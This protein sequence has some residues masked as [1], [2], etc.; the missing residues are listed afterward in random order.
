MTSATQNSIAEQLAELCGRDH[1][2]LADGAL[3]VAPGDTLQIAAILRYANENG[4]VVTPYSGGTKQGWGNPVRPALYLDMARLAT[5]RE[6]TWQDL[7]CTVD[8]GCTW[9]ALQAGLVQHGQSVALDP[10]WPGRATVGGAIATNDSGSLRFYYGSLRDLV[11]GMTIVL[12]D[13]TIAKTGGKV[14]KNVAGYDLHKLM[15]GAFGTLGVITEVTFRLHAIPRHTESLTF[16]A[17]AASTLAPILQTIRGGHFSTQRLQLRGAR[18]GFFL[19]VELAALPSAL[20]TQSQSL[21]ALAQGAGLDIRAADPSAWLGRQQ[22]FLENSI[23]FK[24]S[25]LPTDVAYFADYL[26]A[27][28][29]TSVTQAQGIMTAAIDAEHAGLLPSLREEFAKRGGTLTLL[30]SHATLDPWGVAPDTLPL[31]H[32]VKRRFD[33]NSILNRG[34]FLGEI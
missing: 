28:G 21:T 13:G 19:D 9:S 31:M 23:N 2:R 4:L 22:M 14:V 30:Q 27:R 16:R 11:I 18:D 29:V 33:P 20:T 8:A 12:A 5:L 3:R 25:M 17:D 1:V 34:R 32:E 26:A 24:A 10:L 15:I 7:T 6:H